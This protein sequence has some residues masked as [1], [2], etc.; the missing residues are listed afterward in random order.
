MKKVLSSVILLVLLATLA[1]PTSAQEPPTITFVNPVPGNILELA[2]GESYTFDV[3]V[4]SDVPFIRAQMALDQFFPGRSVFADGMVGAHSGTEA[5][6]HLTVTG[7]F[8]T[9]QFPDGIAPV[10]LIVGVRYQGG[11]VVVNTYDF[12]VIVQ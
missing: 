12:G 11:V 3:Q 8:P 4:S 2:V 9:A 7:K 10:T 1:A 6:L 5:T